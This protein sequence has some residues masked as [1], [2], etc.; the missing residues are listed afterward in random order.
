MASQAQSCD[1][2]QLLA[3]YYLHTFNLRSA[4]TLAALQT[5]LNRIRCAD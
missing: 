1:Q 5:L 4:I 2:N 3:A